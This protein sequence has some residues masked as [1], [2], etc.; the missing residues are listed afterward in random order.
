[1]ALFDSDIK[2]NKPTRKKGYRQGYYRP[3]NPDKYIGD[4]NKIIYRSSYEYRFCRYCDDSPSILKWSSEP[5]GIKYTSPLDGKDHKYYIDFY[6]RMKDADDNDK[7]WDFLVEVKP[8]ESLKKPIYEGAHTVGKLKN[9]NYA[10]K[11][12]LVNSAKFN[13]AKR[14]AESVGYRFVIVTEDFLF[15]YEKR[16]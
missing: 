6:M 13:A 16:K 2:N 10:A 7:E 3:A 5:Y 8:K 15:K 14:H 1:M 11:A 12:W 4:L 9:F